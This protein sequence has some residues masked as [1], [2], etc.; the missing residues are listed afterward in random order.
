VWVTNW[1]GEDYVEV[2][3]L[4]RS[5]IEEAKADLALSGGERVLDVGCGDGHLTR[6]M[7]G[8]VPGGC[9]VGVDA[10]KRMV[11]TAQTAGEATSAGP[12]FVV[13]DARDLPFGAHFDAVV[14]FNALHWVPEQ[15]RALAQIASVLRPAGRALVQVVCAGDR[16]SLETVTMTL[17]RSTVWAQWFDGFSAPFV[18]V[19]PDTFAALA[20][21]A[22]LTLTTMTVTD[23]VWD[24][25]SRNVFA[26]WCAVGSTAWTDRLP[27]RMRDRFTEAQVDAYE[28]VS[29]QPGVFYFTQMRAEL[30]R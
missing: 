13:A 30:R 29:G 24:F 18:H 25:G 6:D 21:S 16:L 12:W 26:R 22:G 27:A 8:M 5:M 1:S 10:S 23:R 28:A 2:S 14:S 7:A 11:A 15:Q 4:Q 3:S 9:V 19:Q 20:T 17:C